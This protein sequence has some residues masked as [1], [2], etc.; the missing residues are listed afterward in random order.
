MKYLERY[1][2][3]VCVILFLL[4]LPL[5]APGQSEK[6]ETLVGHWTFEKGVELED[7]T[8]NL[9]TFSSW[10]LQSKML[11]TVNIFSD[12]TIKSELVERNQD[13]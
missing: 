5:P 11:R 7:L 3:W 12:F 8:G 2:T 6:A 4:N 10:V 1:C 9:P 13:L